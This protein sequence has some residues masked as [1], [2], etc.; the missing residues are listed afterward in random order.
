MKTFFAHSYLLSPGHRIT[1]DLVGVGGTGSQV[2]TCLARINAALV[3]LGHPGL[4]VRAWDGDTVTEANTARQLY[5]RADIGANKAD[6]S[7]SR[8]NRFFGIDWASVPAVYDG[9]SISNILITCIDTADGRIQIAKKIPSMRKTAAKAYDFSRPYLWMDF[10][11]QM[12]TGQVVLGTIIPSKV[13]GAEF[14]NNIAQSLPNVVK[15]LPGIRKVKQAHQGPSCSLAEALDRQ[16]LLINS[17]LAQ[18]GCNILWKLLREG[19]L[20]YHG[21]YLNLSTMT[22]NPIKIH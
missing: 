12:S 3:G 19:Q 15:L 22:T 1:I 14:T 21:V 11:N 7:V 20:K 6:V 10:G 18:L 2:L 16:D 5:S 17:V 4:L 13:K 8:I 9:Q